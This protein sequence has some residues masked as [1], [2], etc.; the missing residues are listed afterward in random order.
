MRVGCVAGSS[1]RCVGGWAGRGWGGGGGFSGGVW[2][3]ACWC[4]CGRELR[5]LGGRGGRGLESLEVALEGRGMR[6]RG[7]AVGLGVGGGGG[8]VGW[9]GGWVE[10]VGSG[11]G[12]GEVEREGCG[13]IRERVGLVGSGGRVGCGVSRGTGWLKWGLWVVCTGLVWGW[14]GWFVVDEIRERGVCGWEV[15]TSQGHG[16]DG[17]SSESVGGGLGC[18]VFHLVGW[19]GWL[20]R[21]IGGVCCRGVAMG[22]ECGGVAI[23]VVGM[24]MGGDRGGIRWGRGVEALR[25]IGVRSR[26]GG[27]GGNV[28]VLLWWSVGGK[29]GAGKHSVELCCWAVEILRGMRGGWLRVGRVAIGLGVGCGLWGVGGGRGMTVWLS[30]SWDWGL[31]GEGRFGFGELWVGGGGF[32]SVVVE[33]YFCGSDGK[34]GGSGLEEGGGGG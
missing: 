20:G 17:R 3:G 7:V 31:V 33:G 2:G 23:V 27:T 5:C 21:S 13:V 4:G 24:R 9:E 25:G 28:G 22:G 34:G 1:L 19:G 6:V 11:V 8:C 12:G 32:G 15:V 14:G 16:I 18:V 29:G 10:W 30:G 26:E